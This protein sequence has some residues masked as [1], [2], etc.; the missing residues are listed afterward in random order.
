MRQGNRLRC[1]WSRVSAAGVGLLLFAETAFGAQP[2][3]APSEPAGSIVVELHPT[4]GLAPGVAR[5]VTFGVPFP[6]GS[7]TPANLAK[8]RVLKGGVEMPAYV[9][10]LT[11]WRHATD[12]AQDGQ[13]VRVAR[14]QVQYTFT[15]SFPASEGVVVEWGSNTRAQDV[16]AFTD[17][18]TAWHLVTSGSFVAADGVREPDVFAVLPR[19]HLAKGALKLTRMDPFDASVSEARD[20]PFAMDAVEH[21]PGFQEQEH[22]AKNNSYTL[23]NEDD[24]RVDPKNFC[25]YKTDYEPWLYDRAAS[26]YVLYFRSGS[27][28]ALREAVRAADFYNN[29]LNA[30]GRFDLNPTDPKYSYNESP[31][32]THWLTGD[33]AARAK[34]G[35]VVSSYSGFPSRWTPSVGFWT[36]RHAAFKLLATVVAYEV[37][38]DAYKA[39]VQTIKGDYL[40]HQ[41]GA[42][43]QIPSPRVDGALYHKGSQ[44]SEGTRKAFIASPWMTVLLVD[45]MLRTYAVT[46]D[47]AVADFLKRVG[48]FLKTVTR[49]DSAHQYDNYSGPLWYADYLSRHDG[50]VDKRSRQF[51]E[52]H[53]LEVGAATAWAGYFA[54]VLGAPDAVLTQRA[55]D[56][57]FT[58]DTGVNFWIRPN[59]PASGLAAFRVSP[60]RKYGWEH[61]P[62]GGY[63]WAMAN[64]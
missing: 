51:M 4:E 60:W 44:H 62:S 29:H 61:R 50:T 20:D 1:G 47:P 39:A 7:V 26:L 3:L 12:P 41:D 63:S 23:V 19:A 52:E 2:F 13:S 53:A 56:L 16:A 42:G 15:A 5:L 48:N 54:A 24:P 35:L 37:L 21:W 32:Y 11:P 6:R 58:Y 17:P 27:F 34:I 36:E 33:D 25:P 22:A 43:G 14:I 30:G 59:A 46:E 38:G 40:W 64:Q 55:T 9:A 49:S 10:Q 8:V 57:Y 45:A 31:A 28:K 18:R